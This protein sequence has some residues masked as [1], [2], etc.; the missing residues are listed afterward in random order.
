[1]PQLLSRLDAAGWLT[2]AIAEIL[3]ELPSLPHDERFRREQV[4][5]ILKRL[6]DVGAPVRMVRVGVFPSLTLYVVQ[7][8]TR[9][10]GGGQPTSLE[11]IARQLPRLKEALEAESVGIVPN[12]R[13]SS[14]HI[15]ILV[16][17]DEHHALRLRNLVL[18]P[19]FQSSEPN[20]SLALGMAL[21]QQPVV[22]DLLTLPHLMLVGEGGHI[23]QLLRGL[24]L[25]LVLFSTPAEVRIAVMNLGGSESGRLPEVL[26]DLP[27]VLG[28]R[29]RQ[30]D[31]SLKL[32]DGLVKECRRRQETLQQHAV[33]DLTAYHALADV[34]SDKVLPRVIVVMEDLLSAAWLELREQWVTLLDELLTSGAK[35][36]IHL[37]MTAHMADESA[38]PEFLGRRVR[39]RVVLA[40]SGN[41]A[42]LWKHS[43]PPPSTFIDGF[44]IEGDSA[45]TPLMI[46]VVSDAELTRVV[47]YW[48]RTEAQRASGQAA[49]A[50]EGQ[51][52]SVLET[53]E[54]LTPV[55]ESA[56]SLPAGRPVTAPLPPPDVLY[57]AAEALTPEDVK[58]A[59]ARAL[60]AYLGWLAH[61]P[62]RDVLMMSYEDAD[63]IIARLQAEGILESGDGP[64]YR[65]IRLDEIEAPED[66]D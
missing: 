22:R 58:L 51:D 16:R 40:T 27:H 46:G 54:N 36:G 47:A 24:L 6:N 45:V 9:R 63:V 10:R 49:T 42:R 48:Q 33:D 59:R 39:S 34:T 43:V 32:L 28:R 25:N 2:P 20:T 26:S 57:R 7:P 52:I 44:L 41:V 29:L 5:T 55:A 66:D 13:S 53:S 8:G 4:S 35:V 21:D 14:E 31:E 62:L 38:L 56:T 23:G 19:A 3:D 61:G 30:A 60:A 37:L 1:M 65:F 11:E 17:M 18:M 15:G 64:I 50:S 12:W